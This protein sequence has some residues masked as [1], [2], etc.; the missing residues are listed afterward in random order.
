[1]L[2]GQ[3][4]FLHRTGGKSQGRPMLCLRLPGTK[5]NPVFVSDLSLDHQP[6]GARH[7]RTFCCVD[8]GG[9][10]AQLSKALWV[11][12]TNNSRGNETRIRG[13]HELGRPVV[14]GFQGPDTHDHFHVGDQKPFV[15]N[16]YLYDRIFLLSV[17]LFLWNEALVQAAE[18][19]RPEVSA[20]QGGVTRQRNHSGCYEHRHQNE[21]Q[22]PKPWLNSKCYTVRKQPCMA[23][24]GESSAADQIASRNMSKDHR[25]RS[26]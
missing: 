4:I 9:C 7:E 25:C 26:Y 6:V 1:M 22:Q 21:P 19:R 15:G 18:D 5:Y 13:Q 11:L 8:E 17:R 12:R 14:Q 3:R 23:R 10:N 16:D 2:R 20:F 24:K